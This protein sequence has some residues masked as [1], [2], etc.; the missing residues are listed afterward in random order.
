MLYTLFLI[1]ISKIINK[2]S[3]ISFLVMFFFVDDLN[4]IVLSSLVKKI[5]KTL[6]KIIKKEIRW[7]SQNRKIQNISKI[8]VVLSS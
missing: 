3:E 5:V 2:I 1:Y 7:E 6:E 8:K 4:F